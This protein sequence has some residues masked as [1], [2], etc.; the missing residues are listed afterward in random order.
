MLDVALEAGALDRVGAAVHALED[1]AL[2]QLAQV[3]ADGLLGHREVRGE[4]ADLDPAVGAGPDQ[5]L[6]LSLVRLH[7]ALLRVPAACDVGH[8]VSLHEGSGS[9][10]PE[11][12]CPGVRFLWGEV[13]GFAVY[14]A[15]RG[16]PDGPPVRPR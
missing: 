14:G 2:D 11:W 1:T 15:F 12:A 7:R 6:S 13:A 4:A 16:S 8:V 5:D 10:E 9:G 3:A